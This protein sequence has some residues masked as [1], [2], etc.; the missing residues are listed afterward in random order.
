[1]EKNSI[2]WV[3]MDVHAAK[4]NVAVFRD[5]NEIQPYEQYES[6]TDERSK[7][8]LVKRLKDLPGEVRCVYEAGPCGYDFQR[9]LSEKGIKCEIAAPSLIPTRAG[10]RVKTDRRDARK[11]GRLY[12]SGELTAIHIPSREQEAIRDLVRVRE[13]AVED[14]ERKRHQL[15]KFLLRHGHRY[16]GGKQWTHGH[17]KWMKTIHFDDDSL[18]MVL[19]EYLL[20]QTQAEDRVERLTQAVEEKAKAPE[21]KRCVA[22]LMTL[23]GVQVV[24]AMTIVSEIGDLR[25]FG[26]AKEFMS[27][28]GLVPSEHSSGDSIHR[29]SITKTGNAHVRRVI[30]ES[31]WH[32]RHR[33]MVGQRI[34]ARRTGQPLEVLQ[35]AQKADIRLNRKFRK[36]VER[37]KRTTIAAVA[38][39][40]ELAG[41]IWAIGQ[42]VHA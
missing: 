26:S 42:K 2:Y 8:R 34:K 4:I 37:G 41:F 1:M 14:R 30:V 5:N 13:D 7:G 22:A 18:Q 19:D 32:Y 16:I 24:T 6:Q 10:D 17:V 29:G 33:P 36:L 27:A 40:R 28:L 31:A 21:Y 15:S 20:T 23:R 35:V 11:L 38:T 39:A 12:R 3:G 25:R 9:Y